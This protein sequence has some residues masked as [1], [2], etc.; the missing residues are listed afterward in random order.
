MA[1]ANVLLPSL[2][3]LHFPD[4]I[5]LVTALYTTALAVGLTAAFVLTVPIADA[6]GGWRYGLGIW[7]VAGGARGGAVVGLVRH[8]RALST[9]RSAT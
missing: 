5:G 6:F 3:R 4:R 2:V 1:M 9:R 8:D 7:A